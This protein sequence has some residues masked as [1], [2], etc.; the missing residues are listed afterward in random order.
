MRGPECFCD[1]VPMT[2]ETPTP[3]KTPARKTPAS[4][5]ASKPALTTKPAAKSASPKKPDA[6]TSAPPMPPAPP[7]IEASAQPAA[8]APVGPLPMLESEARMWAMLAHVLAAVAL[9][10][11]GGTLAFLVPLIVWLI[12]KERSA[13][14]DYHAKQNLNLQLTTIVVM[15]AGILLGFL[16]FF[17]VGF[18]ITGPLMVAYFIYA[19][20]ISIVAGVKANNGE[21]YNI[22]MVIRFI[23]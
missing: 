9:F 7:A 10:V 15:F 12:F 22:P 5:S 20:V 2:E 21:Y 14:V 6:A 1:A 16:I 19:V 23:S 18:I 4:S 13:L 11:S 17:G 3:R 8:A